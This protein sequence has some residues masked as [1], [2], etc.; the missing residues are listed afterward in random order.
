MG[1]GLQQSPL[2][3]SGHMLSSGL[4]HV[5]SWVNLSL[6]LVPRHRGTRRPQTQA[7]GKVRSVPQ[8]DRSSPLGEDVAS[9]PYRAE[10][11]L[12]APD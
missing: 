11:F 6:L 4:G 5:P 2:P 7:T 12:L 3:A 1:G 9:R 10:S 8:A